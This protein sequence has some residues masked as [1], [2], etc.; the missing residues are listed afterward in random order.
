MK[1]CCICTLISNVRTNPQEPLHLEE[2]IC[3]AVVLGASQPGPQL[4]C[5][6]HQILLTVVTFALISAKK[7]HK[8]YV[9][10]ESAIDSAVEE[11]MKKSNIQVQ[12]EVSK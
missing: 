12:K 8:D 2:S 10:N 11:L 3:K 1:D 4:F 7:D 9:A 5:G 6:R